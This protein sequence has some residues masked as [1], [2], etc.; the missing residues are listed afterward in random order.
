MAIGAGNK[1]DAVLAGGI[2][3]DQG[4]AGRGLRRAGHTAN[5]H[6]GL[7]QALAQQVAGII[8]AHLSYQAHRVIQPGH[9]DGLVSSFAAIESLQNA[10]G[11][12][13]TG[14][15]K[16]GHG[17]HHIQ[18]DT[19]YNDHGFGRGCQGLERGSPGKIVGEKRA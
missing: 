8:V 13:F 19:A 17:G 6:S 9:A 12:G 7:A 10:A 18:I 16:A 5:V 11:N 3:E 4:S 2:G 14:D 15:W 1:N